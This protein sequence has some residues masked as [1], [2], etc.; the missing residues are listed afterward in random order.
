MRLYDRNERAAPAMQP[1]MRERP[2]IQHHA[3]HVTREAEEARV[4]VHPEFDA[5]RTFNPTSLVAPPPRPGFAQR[6]I[7]DPFSPLASKTEKRN[8]FSKQRQGYALRD[9][10]TVPTGLR[11]LYPST[12]LADGSV[13]IAVADSLLA[14]IPIAAANARRGAVE[15]R[16]KSLTSAIPES[17]QELMRKGE[18]RFGPVQADDHQASFRGR[19]PGVMA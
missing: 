15:D 17:T 8:W 2:P 7:T 10:E 18:G 11:H 1:S 3:M 9:P 14:E 13:A 16:I 5:D 12:K 4:D 19:N 6:W